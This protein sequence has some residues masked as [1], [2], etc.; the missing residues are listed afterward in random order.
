MSQR[1][2]HEA[3]AIYQ[4][5][6]PDR[7]KGIPPHWF[8]YVAVANVAETTSHVAELG[9]TVEAGPLDVADYGRMSVILD[10]T[11]GHLGLWEAVK[12]PGVGIR[13]EP[14]A[15]CWAELM[16][17]DPARASAFFQRL[18]GWEPSSMSIPGG[19][20][21]VF[22]GEGMPKAGCMG[23]TPE[24]GDVPT[25]W[26][27]YFAVEDC[28]AAIARVNE[29]GGRSMMG[30]ETVPGVGRWAL[31]ADPQGAVFAVIAPSGD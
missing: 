14:G 1:H 30:P 13:D 6:E 28:E 16:T 3:G 18:I 2:G 4:M 25:G 31:L 12:Q 20:Y 24:M 21:T 11:G 19:D 23:I 9:G 5:G 15:L 29:L 8:S 7:A 17:R 10:P 26:L 22:M 27:I